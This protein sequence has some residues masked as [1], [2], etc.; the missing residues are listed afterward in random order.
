MAPVGS[1]VR[2][3]EQPDGYLSHSAPVHV[4][5]EYEVLYHDGSCMCVTSDRPEVDATLYR[6]RFEL[7]SEAANGKRCSKV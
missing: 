2:L 4:G 1:T 6:G 3:I 7:V 5:G